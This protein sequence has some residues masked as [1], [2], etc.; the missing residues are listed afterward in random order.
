MRCFSIKYLS[1]K[2][3][4][5]KIIFSKII[6]RMI[7]L[8]KKYLFIANLQNKIILLLMTSESVILHTRILYAQIYFLKKLFLIMMSPIHNR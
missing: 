1:D 8:K 7:T 5:N 2:V 4:F 6:Y 3:F